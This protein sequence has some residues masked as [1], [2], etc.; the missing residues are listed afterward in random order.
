MEPVTKAEA[1]AALQAFAAMIERSEQAQHK[2]AQGSSQFTLL[3]N[4]IAALRIAA[5]LIKEA[6][7]DGADGDSFTEEELKCAQAPIA[8]LIS[9]SEKTKG[10]LAP[11]SWQ[12][13]MVE[14]NLKA[15]YLALPLV[16]RAGTG[17]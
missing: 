8:S 14:E 11:G 9:K 12:Y 17:V 2:F 16:E 5:S 7:T 1:T 15:L 10:K 6:Y 3:Q 4:R 13:T